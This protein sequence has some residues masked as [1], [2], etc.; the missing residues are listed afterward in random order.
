[1]GPRDRPA[2]EERIVGG[3]CA[4]PQ[5]VPYPPLR[6]VNF[7]SQLQDFLGAA[8][9]GG[10]HRRLDFAGLV[11]A[12]AHV[13]YGVGGSDGDVTNESTT[14]FSDGD[15]PLKRDQTNAGARD[16]RGS[17]GRL[18]EGAKDR[19][20]RVG[21]G[22]NDSARR[23]ESRDGREP[24]SGTEARRGP[25]RRAVI[26]EEAEVRRWERRLGKEQMRRLRE[27][28]DRWADTSSGGGANE[29]GLEVRDLKECF[30]DL[31]RHVLSSELQAWCHE[32]DLVPE[33]T[34]GLADFAYAFHSVSNERSEEGRPPQRVLGPGDP[35]WK[36][37]DLLRATK[38]CLDR[39]F[40][41]LV[42]SFLS[43]VLRVHP[44]LSIELPFFCPAFHPR[45]SADTAYRAHPHPS[46]DE[47]PSNDSNCLANFDLLSIRMQ[48]RFFTLQYAAHVSCQI[49]LA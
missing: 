26:G 40:F 38:F 16:E 35:F 32:A 22:R 9:G 10:S 31:G 42:H 30:R 43:L 11:K 8:A 2:D 24:V 17:R 47:A 27:V 33:D 14:S 21:Y 48:A 13:F 23:E 3:A 1:M 28:F 7:E 19:A 29:K 41:F 5:P 34:L 20:K 4:N 36:R 25:T 46:R 49:D 15:P 39:A 12:Y 6:N 45:L 44:F 37:G 18:E